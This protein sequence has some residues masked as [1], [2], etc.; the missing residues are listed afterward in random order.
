[1]RKLDIV[2]IICIAIVS[3]ATIFCLTIVALFTQCSPNYVA[4]LATSIVLATIEAVSK[5]LQSI[6]LQ[7]CV[8]CFV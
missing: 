7:S 1:M 5:V 4:W 8:I 3:T 2:C 6:S